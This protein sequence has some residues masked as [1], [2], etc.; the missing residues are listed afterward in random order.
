MAE[1]RSPPNEQIP[2]A[3]NAAHTE[4]T[5]PIKTVVL[6]NPMGWHVLA[7]IMV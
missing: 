7:K 6:L 4:T 2:Y 1:C 5:R 3:L